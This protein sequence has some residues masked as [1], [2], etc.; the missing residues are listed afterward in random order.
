MKTVKIS[1]SKKDI[2]LIPLDKTFALSEPPN[3][4]L[5]SL[6]S[7]QWEKLDLTKNYRLL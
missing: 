2:L 3:N 1:Y 6:P 7:I 5:H 4:Y